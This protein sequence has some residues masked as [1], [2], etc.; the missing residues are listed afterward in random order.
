M[1]GRV[2]LCVHLQKKTLYAVKSVDRNKIAKYKLYDNL[3]AER[4]ILL[5][6][7]NVMIMKLVKTWKDE[8]RV[9]FITEFIPGIDLFDAL[10]DIGLW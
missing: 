10:R 1:F 4:E 9:Y 2:Y 3:V 7:D 8:Q 6:I 5:K